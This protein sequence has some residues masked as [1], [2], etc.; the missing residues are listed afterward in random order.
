MN[1]LRYNVS[2]WL[3][4]LF[5]FVTGGCSDYFDVRP[6]SQVLAD[7]L[8]ST[9]EGF[10]DQLTGV[11][12]RLASTSLYG[13]EMTFGLAEA[14]TQNY[15]LATGSE[16]YEA[17]L[18]NYENTAVKNKITTVWSQMYSAIANLNIMLEYIDKNPAMFSGDNYRIYKGEAL[19]LR[20]FLHLDLLR[21][22]APSYASNA[23]APAI[24]YVM[25][26]STAVTPQSTVDKVLDY[27]IADAREA[28]GLLET[29]PL[30]LADSLEAYTYRNDR[31]YRFNYYAVAATLARAYQWKGGADNLAQALVYARKVIEEKKF[32]WVH[33]TSITSSNAYERDL[34][35]ASELLFRLNV[36][37]MDDII[38][39]YFKEQTDKTKK[40]SP[41]EEM[42]DDI[43]EV[44]T[45]A[46][47]QDWRHIYH[48]TYSGSDP[49]LSKFWQ[50]ENGTYKNFMPV[51]RWSEMYYIAAEASLNTDS[52]QA[53]RYLNTVRNNRYL[54]FDPLDENLPV[55]QIQNEIYKEYRKELVGEGQL[56]YYYKRLNF[57]SIPGSAVSGSDDIYVLP[58]PE[59]EVE[60]GNRQ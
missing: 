37:D 31:S 46:Y 30:F 19:G 40:L 51:L 54:D 20:A 27:V 22:F 32:S 50:Y 15:D 42:W 10:S 47:G 8:F 53:V 39:P 28:L 49:Y 41:S 4:A 38:G 36:L 18:Y 43:Y 24:P 25:T 48:W 3:G 34:L 26:Y 52:R 14:L 12:K 59:N 29:D 6:K 16:Y 11:Y 2:F 45:K 58:M 9:E 7:E 60:F 21:M 57:A 33:Y 13:Q 44:S 5:L 55:T 35:F 1:K 23:Q 56:F 17:G